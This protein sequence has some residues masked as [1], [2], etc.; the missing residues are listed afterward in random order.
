MVT[1]DERIL[2]RLVL[3]KVMET[4]GGREYIVERLGEPYLQL[5]ADLLKEMESD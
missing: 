4:D 1:D 3:S 5:A 2:L